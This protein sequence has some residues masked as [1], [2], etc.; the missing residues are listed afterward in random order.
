M[1]LAC[2]YDQGTS[3]TG[4]GGLEHRPIVCVQ[5][6]TITVADTSGLGL[7]RYMLDGLHYILDRADRIAVSRGCDPLPVVV[8]FSS[9][10]LAGPHDGSHPIE[11]A[12]DETIEWQRPGSCERGRGKPAL[13]CVARRQNLHV[14]RALAAAAAARL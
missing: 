2:G 13:A 10:V 1:D 4:R 12:I 6:P 5:L 8:N 3:P 9:G 14:C 11:A 7:E